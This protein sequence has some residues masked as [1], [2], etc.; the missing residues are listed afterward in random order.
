MRTCLCC[1]LSCWASS[2]RS[3]RECPDK[4]LYRR[5]RPPALISTSE[6][7]LLLSSSSLSCRTSSPTL[8]LVERTS[9]S[10]APLDI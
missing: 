8:A 4:D 10:S 3:P 9:S 1:D 6:I 2:P 5:R 7:R